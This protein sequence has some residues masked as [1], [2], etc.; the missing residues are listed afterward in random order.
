MRAQ[1]VRRLVVQSTYGIGDGTKR[2][3][4]G[5][6]A[7]FTLAIRPQV[8]VHEVQE[9]LV[10]ESGL[11]RTSVRPVVLH[12]EGSDGARPGS[13][14]TTTCPPCA[15]DAARWPTSSR[16]PLGRTDWFSRTVSV[17]E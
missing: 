3:P 9:A 12:D 7:F 16:A 14:S 10:R 8:R 11:D 2:L 17:S 1:G 13:C 6:K 4:L 5:L 15:S